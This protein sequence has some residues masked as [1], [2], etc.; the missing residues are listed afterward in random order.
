M[1]WNLFGVEGSRSNEE[2]EKSLFVDWHST[3]SLVRWGMDSSQTEFYKILR[4]FIMFYLGPFFFFFLVKLQS[5][6]L[7][8]FLEITT[9]YTFFGIFYIFC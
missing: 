6:E 7:Y 5:E 2:M 3:S 1:I 4:T 8:F 9:Y